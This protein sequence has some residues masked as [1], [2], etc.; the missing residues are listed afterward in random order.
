MKA[1]IGLEHIHEPFKFLLIMLIISVAQFLIEICHKLW[2][3]H[4]VVTLSF[5]LPMK[6]SKDIW[7]ICYCITFIIF[8]SGHLI[9]S[10]KPIQAELT[11]DGKIDWTT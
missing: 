4:I 2:Q 11:L 1:K 8:F 5:A 7:K 9:W 3:K 10:S 6:R